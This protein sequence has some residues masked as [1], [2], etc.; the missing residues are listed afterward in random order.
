MVLAYGPSRKFTPRYSASHADDPL[1]VVAKALL[2]LPVAG[3][4]GGVEIEN[5]LVDGVRLRLGELCYQEGLQGLGV[6]SILW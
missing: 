2:L 1:V 5:D 6:L 4:V 3:T